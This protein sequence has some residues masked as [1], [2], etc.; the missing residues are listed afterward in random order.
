MNEVMRRLKMTIIVFYLVSL[1]TVLPVE[2]KQIET[3]ETN[4]GKYLITIEI[5]VLY[6]TKYTQCLT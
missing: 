5:Y 2:G 6:R 1:T 4:N 3:N